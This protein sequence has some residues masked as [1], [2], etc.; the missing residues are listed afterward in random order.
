MHGQG[1]PGAALQVAVDDTLVQTTTI[2]PDGTWTVTVTL[3]H[4]TTQTV[5][6]PASAGQG[7]PPSAAFRLYF[8]FI[9]A[10]FTQPGFVVQAANLRA[11]PGLSFP[12]VGRLPAR[13]PVVIVACNATCTWYQ[14]SSAAWIAAFLVQAG[15][16]SPR[17]PRLASP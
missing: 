11:G 2:R 15:P 17:L 16:P 1:E 7:Q 6:G 14:V 10:H 3:A 4:P 12:V 9:T 5:A 13:Q 8:P